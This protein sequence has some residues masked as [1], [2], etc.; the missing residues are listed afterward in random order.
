MARITQRRM[1][2]RKFA[3]LPV[4]PMGMDIISGVS[5]GIGAMEISFSLAYCN[6]AGNEYA[7]IPDNP[8]RRFGHIDRSGLFL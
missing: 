3:S 4:W 6:V 8:V 7:G 2:N 1:R 5:L